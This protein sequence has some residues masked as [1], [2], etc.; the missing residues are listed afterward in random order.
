VTLGDDAI[1][2]RP[3]GEGDVPA[4]T[5]ACQDPEIVRWTRVPSPYTEDDARVF[6][7]S[8]PDHAFAIA[9]QETGELLGAIDA[10]TLP[11]G[12]VDIGYWVCPEARGRGAASRALVLLS[13][14]A[15]DELGA[16]RVQVKVE[17]GNVASLRVAQKAGFEREGTLRAVLEIRGR[18]RDAV[19]LA[20]VPEDIVAQE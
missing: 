17:P 6:V 11:D 2:L 12:V 18:R 9:D 15:F 5:A 19:M 4:V 14:W 7:L 8:A 3:F 13:R 10:R 16:G 1:V 20:L